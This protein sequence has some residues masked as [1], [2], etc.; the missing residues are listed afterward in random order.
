M[1]GL[2]TN[3]LVR[4]LVQDD[5]VQAKQATRLIE[6]HCTPDAPGCINLIVLCET[7]WVL[8]SAYGFSRDAISD[9]IDQLLHAIEIVVE[10]EQ[11]VVAALRLFRSGKIDFADALIAVRN[12]QLGCDHTATFDREALSIAGFRAVP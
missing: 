12:Q 6:R 5:P 2:D 3:V 1:I 4:Y 7:V 9:V 10:S 11:T 8:T